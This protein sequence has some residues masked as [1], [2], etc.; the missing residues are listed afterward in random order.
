MKKFLVLL[1]ALMMTGVNIGGVATAS[2]VSAGE[3]AQNAVEDMI[4][5]DAGVVSNWMM[6]YSID[7]AYETVKVVTGTP[8]G[9]NWYTRRVVM[10]YR[11]YEAGITEEE[12]DEK[13]ASLGVDD[14]SD[15]AIKMVDRENT[16]QQL[17]SW[18][19]KAENDGV[20]R[21]KTDMIYYALMVAHRVENSEGEVSWEDEHWIRGKIDYRNCVHSKVYNLKT[22]LCRREVNT[23]TGRMI[24]RPVAR[25][26]Y[27][28]A[29][30]P[31]DE[32]IMSWEEEWRKIQ[33]ERVAAVRDNLEMLKKSFSQGKEILQQ[34]GESLE[35][36]DVTLGKTENV[37][38]LKYEVKNLK[39]LLEEVKALMDATD[40]SK[41][42]AELDELRGE[43]AKLQVENTA[44]LG[45]KGE[46]LEKIT[47]QADQIKALKSEKEVI[48]KENAELMTKSGE[49]ETIIEELRSKKETLEA[50]LEAIKESEQQLE[51]NI[52]ALEN[53]KA[54]LNQEI[55]DLQIANEDLKKELEQ[56]KAEKEDALKTNEILKDENEKLGEK[57]EILRKEN[58][59]VKEENESLLEQL[60]TLKEGNIDAENFEETKAALEAENRKLN[61]EI[62]R[63][64][65]ELKEK[66]YKVTGSAMGEQEAFADNNEDSEIIMNMQDIRENKGEDDKEIAAEVPQLGEVET[67][68][69]L[70]W[71]LVPGLVLVGMFGYWIKRLCKK[72]N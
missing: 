35:N 72:A 67:K 58:E 12:A 37:D 48:L 13:L 20:T 28:Q 39:K 7:P 44:I 45:E 40:T 65:V 36:L 29:A 42:E 70:W 10:V 60:K 63:L 43:I 6:S 11:N 55:L 3:L 68:F 71:L 25:P 27:N 69:N 41:L 66:T 23:A 32:V 24:Y 59:K 47:Q 54:A 2:S 38:D 21:N 1:V 46:L 53:E 50:E 51:Q 14:S 31:E 8:D 4:E 34:A 56:A 17:V 18:N 5:L 26:G 15:W 19:L 22:S 64:K 61:S 62:E 52:V 57:N 49:L 16:G 9:G 30:Q 33:E